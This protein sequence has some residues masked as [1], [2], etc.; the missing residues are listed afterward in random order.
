MDELDDFDYNDPSEEEE[1]EEE[2]EDIYFGGDSLDISQPCAKLFPEFRYIILSP[3]KIQEKMFE[4]VDEVNNVFQ[5]S[6]P[7]V[8]V[9]LSHFRWDKE[10]LMSRYYSGDQEALFKEAHVVCPQ[11]PEPAHP[12]VS[13]WHCQ[14]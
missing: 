4:L 12:K 9:L 1:E 10:E 11:K 6:R 2:E 8:R 14:V 13:V 7:I 3:E 5:L